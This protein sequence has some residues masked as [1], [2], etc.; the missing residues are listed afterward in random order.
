MIITMTMCSKRNG[1][2]RPILESTTPAVFNPGVMVELEPGGERD[3]GR[4][5][6]QTAWLY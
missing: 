1:T 4:E 2:L 5:E 6:T 3:S